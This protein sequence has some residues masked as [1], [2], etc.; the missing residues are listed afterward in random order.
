MRAS[1]RYRMGRNMHYALFH[2][3]F[4][5]ILPEMDS[6]EKNNGVNYYIKQRCGGPT[7]DVYTPIIE[8]KTMY[9]TLGD[10]IKKK[11]KRIQIEKRTY[12][13]GKKTIALAKKGEFSFLQIGSYNKIDFV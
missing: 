5:L 1:E 11:S 8:L 10:Y 3:Q 4:I 9:K 12:W 6:V 13:I 7:I 2:K